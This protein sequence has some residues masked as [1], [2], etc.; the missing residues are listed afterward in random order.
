MGIVSFYIIV[1]AHHKRVRAQSELNLD[2]GQFY[3][4]HAQSTKLVKLGAKQS[5][6]KEVRDVLFRSNEL[7]S[8]LSALDVVT[9]LEEPHLHVF[10]FAG[11][12]RIIRSEDR[13][14]VATVQW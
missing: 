3:L 8:Q 9:V 5:L 12:L 2:F 6:R 1:Y 10:I 14:Q 7:D 11:R 13:S 4:V